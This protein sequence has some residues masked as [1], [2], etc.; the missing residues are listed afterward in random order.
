LIIG[1]YVWGMDRLD[2]RERL[3]REQER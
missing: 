3:R 1:L 2:R